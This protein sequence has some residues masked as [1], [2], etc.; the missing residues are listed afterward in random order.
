MLK[1]YCFLRPQVDLQPHGKGKR[2][3]VIPP[4]DGES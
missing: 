4:L 2:K 1:L 3:S